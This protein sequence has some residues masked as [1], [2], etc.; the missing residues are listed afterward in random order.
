MF[1]VCTY[2]ADS[3][4]NTYEQCE[5]NWFRGMIYHIYTYHNALFTSIILVLHLAERR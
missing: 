5:L 4:I 2:D 1:G 3:M